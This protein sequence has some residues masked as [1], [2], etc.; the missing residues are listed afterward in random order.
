MYRL[1]A[2]P[3]WVIRLSDGAHIC[4]GHRWWVEYQAW[5]ADGNEPLPVEV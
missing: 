5:L 1:S 2:N 3:E 4:E